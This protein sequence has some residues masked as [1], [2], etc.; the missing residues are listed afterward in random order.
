MDPDDEHRPLLPHDPDRP[1]AEPARGPWFTLR[2]AF[3]ATGTFLCFYGL[4]KPWVV[5]LFQ[6]RPPILGMSPKVAI[7]VTQMVSYC[8]GK[9][10]GVGL[11]SRVPQHKLRRVLVLSGC[12]A[13]L[14]WL[15][16][17]LL[18]YGLCTLASAAL[19]GFPLALS[20]SLIYR[21]GWPLADRR[22]E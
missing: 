22:G 17:T 16:F 3:F 4:R 12:R 10:F 19:G 21:C 20:W 2:L 18:P 13:V 14:A 11:V 15:G 9:T 8:C 6:D 5:L 7:A 1:G